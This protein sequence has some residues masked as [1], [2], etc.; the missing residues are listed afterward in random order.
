[1]A[2]I[3]GNSKRG[4]PDGIKSRKNLKP[5]KKIPIIIKDKLKDNAIANVNAM[6]AVTVNEKGRRP[7]KLENNIKK[8]CKNKLEKI[9]MLSHESAPLISL[10]RIHKQIQE[11]IAI[12]SEQY[13][14]H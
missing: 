5:F 13:G 7:N 4:A 9:Q 2:T 10:K 6:W 11:N 1:M 12:Y 8:K 3:N 14:D